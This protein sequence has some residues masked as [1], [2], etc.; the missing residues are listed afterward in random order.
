M[1]RRARDEDADLVD[2]ADQ[3]ELVQAFEVFREATDDYQD[4][5]EEGNRERI[6]RENQLVVESREIESRVEH[7]LLQQFQ[8]SSG[9]PSDAAVSMQG[10]SAASSAAVVTVREFQ[11]VP[12]AAAPATETFGNDVNS[13]GH[14]EDNLQVVGAARVGEEPVDV[15]RNFRGGG[16][17]AAVDKE[18]GE[19]PDEEDEFEEAM[20]VDWD[21]PPSSVEFLE[22]E[23]RKKLLEVH[24][25]L[26]REMA[27]DE[28][29]T[30]D[31]VLATA[32]LK[33]DESET[34]IQH[35]GQT[36]AAQNVW[37]RWITQVVK[38]RL[39]DD[40]QFRRARNLQED[41]M[42]GPRD[43]PRLFQEG[44]YRAGREQNPADPDQIVWC[45]MPSKGQPVQEIFDLG[46]D[47]AL[48]ERIMAGAV[49]F[50]PKRRPK[51]A[52]GR[53]E[54][55]A[56]AQ[57]SAAGNT[58]YGGSMRRRLDAFG[59]VAEDGETGEAA[60][61]RIDPRLLSELKYLL[62]S[63]GKRVFHN[64]QP[65]LVDRTWASNHVTRSLR[66]Q[67]L[68]IRLNESHWEW[69]YSKWM[70]NDGMFE[71]AMMTPHLHYNGAKTHVETHMKPGGGLT[72][73]YQSQY[74]DS[75]VPLL[76]RG[77][78]NFYGVDLKRAVVNGQTP[79]RLAINTLD[80]ITIPNIQTRCH[81]IFFTSLKPKTMP[82]QT[83]DIYEYM[84]EMKELWERLND[85]GRNVQGPIQMGGY[86][87]LIYWL[88]ESSTL[89]W[90]TV[91]AI[92]PNQAN[93]T[94]SP[95]P[96]R[97]RS[98][99]YGKPIPQPQLGTMYFQ[100]FM[101]CS[102]PN[103]EALVR[104][105]GYGDCDAGFDGTKGSGI[106]AFIG[107]PWYRRAGE[108][109]APA[110]GTAGDVAAT[111]AQLDE[112]GKALDVRSF[113][114]KYS[115]P[116][117]NENARP[118]S[119]YFPLYGQRYREFMFRPV[120]VQTLQTFP[121]KEQEYGG[122]GEHRG[123]G[124]Q[125]LPSYLNLHIE[126]S[127]FG[128]NASREM[129]TDDLSTSEKQEPWL[130]REFNKGPSARAPAPPKIVRCE[131]NQ[132]YPEV[133]M[134]LEGDMKRRH[135]D[136]TRFF[137]KKFHMT[138]PEKLRAW[139]TK[140]ENAKYRPFIGTDG[141][142]L[143]LLRVPEPDSGLSPEVREE[144]Y[145]A[146]VRK[147]QRQW[148]AL[149]KSASQETRMLAPTTL[150]DAVHRYVAE[151]R[152]SMAWTKSGSSELLGTGPDQINGPGGVYFSCRVDV[153]RNAGEGGLDSYYPVSNQAGVYTIADVM[154]ARGV[155]DYLCD[156]GRDERAGPPHWWKEEEER[157]KTANVSASVALGET[158]TPTMA[159][160]FLCKENLN[161]W[162]ERD[163]AKIKQWPGS[164]EESPDRWT[165]P[166]FPEIKQWPGY[167]DRPM[168]NPAEDVMYHRF[169]KL[170]MANGIT[171]TTE[172]G[173][174]VSYSTS[175][176][177]FDDFVPYEKVE[178]RAP[179]SSLPHFADWKMERMCLYPNRLSTTS[180]NAVYR[181]WLKTRDT[182]EVQ[183]DNFHYRVADTPVDPEQI[184]KGGTERPATASST[185]VA[186]CYVL[187]LDFDDFELAVKTGE[188]AWQKYF[189]DYKE[190]LE[191]A[192]VYTVHTR[193]TRKGEEKQY[194]MVNPDYVS[195]EVDIPPREEGRWASYDG[196]PPSLGRVG[197]N[198]CF[199][200]KTRTRESWKR[201]KLAFGARDATNYAKTELDKRVAHFQGLY[202]EMEQ[203]KTLWDDL[204]TT[205]ENLAG[206]FA[207]LRL[208]SIRLTWDLARLES[209][210]V[211]GVLR[212][213]RL[214]A[215]DTRVIG[216]FDTA[217]PR[218]AELLKAPVSPQFKNNWRFNI[219]TVIMLIDMTQTCGAVRD[220]LSGFEDMI[221]TLT[222]RLD[223]KKNL[224]DVNGRDLS[225][226][227]NVDALLGSVSH[228]WPTKSD[229][230]SKLSYAGG[231]IAK[232]LQELR[233]PEEDSDG[234][235]LAGVPLYFFEVV[236]DLIDQ[237]GVAMPPY[238]LRRNPLERFN[239]FQRLRQTTPEGLAEHMRQMKLA[240][241]KLGSIND[242]E[243]EFEPLGQSAGLEDFLRLFETSLK[244]AAESGLPSHHILQLEFAPILQL[245]LDV[246]AD[247]L[248]QT[249]ISNI[250]EAA[251]PTLNAEF[252]SPGI[253]GTVEETRWLT[254]WFLLGAPGILDVQP[255]S[256]YLTADDLAL[257]YPTALR[258]AALRQPRT[259]SVRADFDDLK[260]AYALFLFGDGF[261]PLQYQRELQVNGQLDQ[262]RLRVEQ[263]RASAVP[264][265]LSQE[266]LVLEATANAFGTAFAL[267]VAENEPIDLLWQILN[268]R[269]VMGTF[270]AET[271]FKTIEQRLDE[272]PNVVRKAADYMGFLAVRSEPDRATLERRQKELAWKENRLRGALKLARALNQTLRATQAMVSNLEGHQP[273]TPAIQ[274]RTNALLTEVT[275]IRGMYQRA[276]RFLAWLKRQDDPRKLYTLRKFL[277]QDVGRRLN[278]TKPKKKK[279]D[280]EDP[281]GQVAPVE[282][283][284]YIAQ[285]VDI[286]AEELTHEGL[287]SEDGDRP[288]YSPDAFDQQLTVVSTPA[289][290][291]EQTLINN[292][293]QL[294]GVSQQV[295]VAVLD[296]LRANEHVVIENP[297]DFTG[298]PNDPLPS[299]GGAP[300][301][302]QA[303]GDSPLS[304]DPKAAD[305]AS[306]EKKSDLSSMLQDPTIA[307]L[308]ETD[309]FAT[310]ERMATE[311]WQAVREEQSRVAA[312]LD[313]RATAQKELLAL[314]SQMVAYRR[315]AFLKTL[316]DALKGVSSDD[317]T[318]M[319][320]QVRDD[321]FDGK[322]ELPTNTDEVPKRLPREIPANV[323]HWAGYKLYIAKELHLEVDRDGK[324]H[325][326]FTEVPMTPRQ[327][328]A[329]PLCQD[330]YQEVFTTSTAQVPAA[331]AQ[332][333]RTLKERNNDFLDEI[334]V[335]DELLRQ[336]MHDM[337]NE[338]ARV[339]AQFPWETPFAFAFGM[340]V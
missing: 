1:P 287:A 118:N 256:P 247:F 215:G 291:D 211:S 275:E 334:G 222:Q 246:W 307:P 318:N 160:P 17:P 263:A 67:F 100:N 127:H 224:T 34:N 203:N 102:V 269:L 55:R 141:S 221:L 302:Q 255:K 153:G 138:D 23:K 176:L 85:E 69:C 43:Y 137:K 152:R 174:D 45:I 300:T 119:T 217:D 5:V 97:V 274:D 121:P 212:P 314:F 199:R 188:A 239:T 259:G 155:H 193:T 311:T 52:T 64:G 271:A 7:G 57:R 84:P 9:A 190:Y 248:I 132:R 88:D 196:P 295:R 195:P 184:K 80:E 225:G 185:L 148:Q 186:P 156:E 210:R 19:A 58:F 10:Q 38:L 177:L 93:G 252:P 288:G 265:N 266:D 340:R 116:K 331:I 111:I 143:P 227:R 317:S 14:P 124:R 20:E 254:H 151:N 179:E 114:Y 170:K 301:A 308:M 72:K 31:Q 25:K 158:H 189:S 134:S 90:R 313:E 213:R 51:R 60:M 159:W 285:V 204:T 106:S 178:R 312:A 268:G 187:A 126:K 260:K 182:S 120:P 289:N 310:L 113:D 53:R 270:A 4:A 140:R 11:E 59:N 123:S 94:P 327:W 192:D 335:E 49:I 22:W 326:S 316:N 73:P 77:S 226:F 324:E 149:Y 309:K 191:F 200:P 234:I 337:T 202:K 232:L 197:F 278:L 82:S 209:C 109:Q 207:D 101:K 320:N 56:P 281:A 235:T 205:D 338:Q 37:R 18:E 87:L 219:E 110:G 166:A 336:T 74:L 71:P 251:R 28:I 30:V 26:V 231:A 277:R 282:R 135:E 330:D 171:S 279:T 161:R 328:L 27:G 44:F 157:I 321:L 329:S 142:V 201:D 115:N 35:A 128:R 147:R 61:E 315:P 262:E 15:S 39:T 243:D 236:N 139:V 6:E 122:A 92:C 103:A 63:D 183:G 162:N 290:A 180:K 214:F 223:G 257:V 70:T 46:A 238:N 250:A 198:L 104:V 230:D 36:E 108:K 173:R 303:G 175:S 48:L 249:R 32:Y 91:F 169:R 305:D 167:V 229:V 220:H 16:D 3:E 83:K 95:C 333:K 240:R 2:R 78:M 298:R 24:Q 228:D 244:E 181:R 8:R 276:T 233:N 146:D 242:D 253:Q 131:M 47:T 245:I 62:D 339:G 12:P 65:R 322:Y 206:K 130:T 273:Q 172:F 293:E 154:L 144:R 89:S 68:P 280:Q 13:I 332:T 133:T 261:D 40:R 323:S 112:Y 125:Q 150:L 325:W 258:P 117:K 237:S 296:V 241:E 267:M 216:T 99:Q 284:S 272:L 66:L 41:L 218:L 306:E 129:V 297:G 194:L 163:F 164:V 79:V 29:V 75:A 294:A 168:T 86:T 319:T 107:R 286:D 21:K 76:T 292:A 105:S 264:A 283:D 81:Q 33:V 145:K 208:H 165:D 299:E 54:F 50:F 98:E 304:L 96:K 42:I 136:M